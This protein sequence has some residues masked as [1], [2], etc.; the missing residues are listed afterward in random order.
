[1]PRDE[2]V[3]RFADG[4]ELK[5]FLSF[6]LTEKFS[7]PLDTF[8]FQAAPTERNRQSYLDR[9]LKG[10]L[11]TVTLNGHPQAGMMIQEVSTTIGPDGGLTFD[12]SA[13]SPI[14]ILMESTVDA[15]V[16]SKAL[17]AAVPMIEMV[18][19]V[20]EPYGFTIVADES[21]TDIAKVKSGKTVS[22]QPTK[23][24]SAKKK[25]ATAEYN[26]SA[27]GFI[28]R[29]LSRAGTMLRCGTTEE[30]TFLYITAP[31]YDS[32]PLYSVK[33]ARSGFGPAADRFIGD[34]T[35]VDTNESQFSFCE[36]VGESADDTAAARSNK[37][38]ARVTC[39][40]INAQRPPFRASGPFPYKPKF[41]KDKE[42]SD[43]QL[44]ESVARFILGTR[45]EKAFTVQGT[46]G[47]F[48][49]RDGTPWTVDTLCSVFVEA[50][51]LNEDMWLAERVM[52]RNSD[53][54]TT[55]LTL[56]PK[57]YL[58]LGDIP[59]AEA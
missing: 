24:K 51:G 57:G 36:V 38:K 5:E 4:A 56:I 49:S 3:V 7:N 46:V 23:H 6:E 50:T 11:V 26:E 58:Q 15:P 48:T 59:S 27:F 25:D 42:S 43:A 31:H 22:K 21:D 19:G 37:P 8:T 39:D 45:A 40:A 52:R 55:R 28:T 47:G 14:Q 12:V 30:G 2:V 35:I 34:I 16:A 17:K 53:G 13:V 29:M 18:L 20:V 9:L 33:Q 32:K 44:S 10:E 54:D 41:H 1:M